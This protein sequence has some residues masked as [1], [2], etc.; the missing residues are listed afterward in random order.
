MSAPEQQ[1]ATTA[2]LT[3]DTKKPAPKDAENDKEA[4]L[5]GLFDK[6]NRLETYVTAYSTASGKS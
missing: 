4:F 1:S 2:S 3:V 6:L 5:S